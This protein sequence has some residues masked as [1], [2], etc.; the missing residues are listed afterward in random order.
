[1]CRFYHLRN[2]LSTEI[3]QFGR[4][5]HKYICWLGLLWRGVLADCFR[6]E[7]WFLILWFVQILISDILILLI[8][9]DYRIRG[10]ENEVGDDEENCKTGGQAGVQ[11]ECEIPWFRCW[12]M[13]IEAVVQW[14]GIYM[15]QISPILDKG[16]KHWLCFIWN[17]LF[18]LTTKH[19]QI[20]PFVVLSSIS[21]LGLLL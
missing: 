12:S 5:T 21:I 3:L 4:D 2:F 18:R 13:L 19:A 20:W 17:N 16:W 14:S 10:M 7:I 6:L 9:Y 8:L 11:Y 15:S 1:M